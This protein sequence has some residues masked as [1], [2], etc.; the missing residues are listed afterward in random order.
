MRWLSL[1]AFCLFMT[2]CASKSYVVLVPSPDGTVGEISVNTSKGTTIV[3]QA[4]Q[5][6]ALD[7]TS[8]QPFVVEDQK[9]QTDFHAAMAAQPPI[10]IYF[11]VYFKTGNTSMTPESDAFIPQVLAQVRER[12]GVAAVSVVGH[13]DTVGDPAFNEQLGLQRA[14][15]IARLLQQTGLQ[16]LELS[17]T[18]H[19]ERNLLIKT[20]DNTPEPRNRRVEVTIR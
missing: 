12:G 9:L 18:S 10:P 19:G 14:R 3:N 13:T 8:P 20:P 15:A 16:A 17:V 1:L 7:G 4:Q 11:Q 2:G 6:V 5:A